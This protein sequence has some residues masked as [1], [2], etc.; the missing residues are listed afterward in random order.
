[1]QS[2]RCPSLFCRILLPLA[3]LTGTIAGPKSASGEVNLPALFDMGAETSPVMEGYRP[4]TASDVYSAERGYGFLE[5]GHRGFILEM[6]PPNSPYQMSVQ[7]HFRRHGSPL[8]VDGVR[9]T[10]DISFRMDVPPGRYRVT[11]SMGDLNQAMGGISL[12]ANDQLI[13][14]NLR[15]HHG[16]Y[17]S[18]SNVHRPW[19]GSMGVVGFYDR[20]RFTVDAPD[21][22]IVLRMVRDE[23]EYNR[24]LAIEKTK[25]MKVGKPITKEKFESL[26]EKHTHDAPYVDI[27]EPFVDI[28]LLGVEIRPYTAPPVAMLAHGR[29]TYS[30][31]SPLVKQAVQAFNEK[32]FSDAEETLDR[33]AAEEDALGAALA[34]MWLAGWPPY[35]EEARIVPKARASLKKALKQSPDNAVAL[36]ASET[37]RDF[38]KALT[39]H[40]NRGLETSHFIDN[41]RACHLFQLAQPGDPLYGKARLYAARTVY[42]LDPVNRGNAAAA[43][44][45]E[46][47]KQFL[48]VFPENRFARYYILGEFNDREGVWAMPD[49]SEIEKGAP[50]W[51]ARLHEVFNRMLD[52]SEW[53]IEHKQRPDGSIGGGWGDDVEFVGLFGFY[54]NVSEGASPKSL[55][56]AAKLVHGVFDHSG[57]IDP[58]TNFIWGTADTEHATEWTGDTLPM[59][60][61]I[62]FGNPIWIERAMA[63]AKLM[64]NL[65]TGINPQGHRHFR[66][67]YIGGMGVGRGEEDARDGNFAWRGAYPID[68][69]HW[70]SQNPVIEKLMLEWADAWLEDSMATTGGKP[71]GVIPQEISYADGTPYRPGAKDWTNVFGHRYNYKMAMLLMGYRISEDPEYLEPFRLCGEE[72]DRM[73]GVTPNRKAPPGTPE[74]I[75]SALGEA[76]AIWEELGNHENSDEIVGLV[77]GS[78]GKTPYQVVAEHCVSS[79]DQFRK[80]WPVMTTEASAT[81]RVGFYGMPL[82]LRLMTGGGVGT[83]A[84]L[85][86]SLTYQGVGRDLAAF[87]LQNSFDRLSFVVYVFRDGIV[88][89][90]ARPWDLHVGWTYRVTVALDEDEDGEPDGP[91]TVTEFTLSQRGKSCPLR[92]EGRKTHIVTLEKVRKSGAVGLLPDLAMW[93][94]DI[95]YNA[96]KRFIMMRVHNIGSKEVVEVPVI[97]YEGTPEDGTVIGRSQISHLDWPKTLDP[98]TLKF[99]WRYQPTSPEATFTAV[100][101]PDNSV[102]EIVETNNTVTRV[103]HFDHKAD[104]TVDTAEAAS[105]R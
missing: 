86:A 85:S 67:N 11:V 58:E 9:D 34:Y 98:Q 8:M 99:G 48:K 69:V 68:R 81:D 30:G 74:K 54:G 83:A 57:D 88:E 37:L 91:G 60:I 5:A 77:R 92:I 27:G 23:S 6:P 76:K 20:I 100:V 97:L 15:F 17:R 46:W 53:W 52:L 95:E 16:L 89:V 45:D 51:A 31:Q 78:E 105:G 38:D 93:E 43:T 33:G 18:V 29:L 40:L 96:D 28:P 24:L 104:S 64:E 103:L 49:Y 12:Y 26:R 50:E 75:K 22:A 25:E 1:M 71:R 66:S 82:T 4:V 61:L 90:G 63:S 87:V 94:H 13:E 3:F 47:M 80:K 7:D 35:E 14:Q 70:Y 72:Y 65:W 102:D 42:Q 10:K 84:A 39:R 19:S 55:E 73:T 101:D 32:R 79:L 41:V 21:G 56:G 62:D 44:A 2:Y 59:M 36:E